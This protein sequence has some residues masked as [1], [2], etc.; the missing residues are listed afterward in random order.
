MLRRLSVSTK[1]KAVLAVPMIVLLAA[2]AIIGGSVLSNLQAAR[3]NAAVVTALTEFQ[4]VANALRTEQAASEG[5]VDSAELADARSSTDTAI[6]EYLEIAEQVSTDQLP[7]ASAEA[8]D[9]M[10]SALDTTLASARDQA[11][12]RTGL[13][14]STYQSIFTDQIL[15]VETWSNE[16]TDR[17]L[18]TWVSVHGDMLALVNTEMAEH[19]AALALYNLGSDPVR[20]EE[21]VRSAAAVKAARS[22]TGS[23]LDSVG[24]DGGLIRSTTSSMSKMRSDLNAAAAASVDPA[25]WAQEINGELKYMDEADRQ[26][27]DEAKS[28]ADAEARANFLRTVI[29]AGIHLVVMVGAWFIASTVANSIVKPLRRLTV[30]SADV[31]EQLPRIVE[32]MAVPGEGPDIELPRIPVESNDE[33]GRLAAAFNEVNATTIQVAQEQAALRGS[34]A[35]MFVNVARR[36]QVLL[37]RQLAFIDSLERSEEDPTVLANLFH[38][39]HL[40]TR[41]RRNAESLLVLAGID[42]GRRLRE[43][44]PLSDVIRTASSEIEQYDRVE[45]DLNVDPLMLGFNALPAAH[46]LAE[47]LENASVFSEPDTPVEV[48][49][50]MDGGFV[51]VIVRDHGIGMTEPEIAQVNDKLRSTSPGDALGAQRLGLFVVARLARRL[52]SDVQIRRSTSGPG[53]EAMVRFPVALFAGLEV[54]PMESTGPG[55][56]SDTPM[57]PP[58][59]D[60]AGLFPMDAG[61]TYVP[62]SFRQGAALVGSSAPNDIQDAWASQDVPDAREVDLASLTDGTTGLGLPR[63]R[64]GPAE[65]VDSGTFVLPPAVQAHQLP[66]DLDSAPMTGGFTPMISANASGLPSRRRDEAPAVPDYPM[67]DLSPAAPIQPEER[68]S[69][70][71]GFRGWSR[72]AEPEDEQTPTPARVSPFGRPL[73]EPTPEAFQ[74]GSADGDYADGDYAENDYTQSGYSVPDQSAVTFFTAPARGRRAAHAAAPARVDLPYGHSETEVA[75]WHTGPVPIVDPSEGSDWPSPT[76]DSAPWQPA[77]LFTRAQEDGPLVPTF[78]PVA[79][80]VTEEPYNPTAFDAAAAAIFDQQQVAQSYGAPE[81]EYGSFAAERHEA[82]PVP[83]TAY[84]SA[85]ADEPWQPVMDFSG[86]PLG[87]QRPENDE[88]PQPGGPLPAEQIWNAQSQHQ[89][90]AAA[91]V[92][93]WEQPQWQAEQSQPQ[94]QAEQSQPQ[95]QAEQPQYPAQ[96]EPPA[97][98]WNAGAPVA[99]DQWAAAPAGPEEPLWPSVTGAASTATG[100]SQAVKKKRGLFGRKKKDGEPATGAAPVWTAPAGGNEPVAAPFAGGTFAPSQTAAGFTPTTA[101]GSFAPVDEPSGAW[102]PAMGDSSSGPARASAAP[103][104]PGNSR[105]ASLDD[106]VAAML[107]L[108]SDIEEQALAEL[109]QLSAYRPS[110]DGSA[111]R[112]TR[113]VPSS[114]P[115]A[116]PAAGAAPIRRDAD[117]LRSRLA[118]FQ[119]GTSR[120]RR[121][122]V[123]TKERDQ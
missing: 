62:P 120:G 82:P 36:D 35:E 118:S 65:N 34:I 81:P 33:I 63:R 15:F 2:G 26:V 32:Q 70:F 104:A 64:T 22:V 90:A 92:E 107:A 14:T 88:V 73:P 46:M 106:D 24:L 103:S 66:Q 39:D 44:M 27:L 49:T 115:A 72:P 85:I 78:D 42:S 16:M 53:T 95:W 50:G 97:Q 74:Q 20:Q 109:S 9:Q 71:T 108:R 40:A 113:R 12:S 30:T 99:A 101:G 28:M 23:H 6:K 7:T 110:M 60:P 111:E 79:L 119:S 54:D 68:Q 61:D 83:A 17:P 55:V 100:E 114:V 98:E 69:L 56:V 31:R 45:L 19:R 86:A 5:T 75:S 59:V 4:D 116:A 1:V 37:N 87:R 51:T 93:Q 18:A 8:F 102:A 29:T 121:A 96:A 13:V 94:W 25:E 84:E 67:L 89:D 117:E 47:L 3:A 38:L 112:L 58:M 52:G 48:A 41:M 11:D 21:Y 76:W 77:G 105:P 43:S 57:L 123:D 91:P 122:S 80:E 10:T